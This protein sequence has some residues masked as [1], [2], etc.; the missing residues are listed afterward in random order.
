MTV[1][2]IKMD[3]GIRSTIDAERVRSNWQVLCRH[4]TGGAHARIFDHGVTQLA[5]L[6]PEQA[7]EII[8]TIRHSIA[9]SL[10]WA[11]EE[12]VVTFSLGLPI[13]GKLGIGN[14]RFNLRGTRVAMRSLGGR[15]V[16]LAVQ[17]ILFLAVAVGNGPLDKLDLFR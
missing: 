14:L 16:R 10:N 9:P 7:Q 4:Y 6:S 2:G 1:T 8:Y 15:L 12:K 3:A 5:K 11:L 13:V 17:G